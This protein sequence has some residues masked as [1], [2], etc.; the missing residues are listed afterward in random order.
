MESQ[1][2]LKDGS[3]INIKNLEPSDVDKSHAFFLTFPKDQ[4]VYFR[5][6]VEDRN[7]I[8]SRIKTCAKGN[9]VRRVVMYDGIIV[10][11]G[12]L[13]IET[14]SWKSGEAQLRLVVHPDFIGKGIQFALAKD[15]YDIADD[16]HIN[17]LI[18]KFM[19]PQEGLL[20]IYQ[21][22]GFKIGGILPNYVVDHS[23]K[24]QDMMVMIATLDE[25]RKAYHFIGDWLD[26]DLSAIGAGEI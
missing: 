20:N 3:K 1:Y 21:N 16:K 25:L 5:S 13:E 23:G 8:I 11:D 18:T 12:S 26:G 14:K 24:E 17:K 15:L 6:N 19:R 22:L 2:E 4:R 9:I 7:H 10:G